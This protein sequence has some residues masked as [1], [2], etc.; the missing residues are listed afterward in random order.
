MCA[1]LCL[2]L[3]L[4]KSLGELRWVC[5]VAILGCQLDYIWNEVQSRNEGHTYER[6]LFFGLRGGESTSSPGL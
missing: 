1:L 3:L 5:V 4:L 2:L 6:I